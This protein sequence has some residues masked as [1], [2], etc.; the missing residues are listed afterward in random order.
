VPHLLD[1]LVLKVLLEQVQHALGVVHIVDPQ[2]GTF[3]YYLFVCL[4]FV[5]NY[6]IFSFAIFVCFC[7][8]CLGEGN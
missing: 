6:E 5:R 3:I 7:N 2:I 1:L 8:N 4:F